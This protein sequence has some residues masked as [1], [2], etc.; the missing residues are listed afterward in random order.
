MMMNLKKTKKRITSIHLLDTPGSED[1][2][3]SQII[4]F[5]LHTIYNRPIQEKYPKDSRVAM[6]FSCTGK[7]RKFRSTK[8][9]PADKSSITMKIK[10]ANL[11]THCWK[12]CLNPNYDSMG[13][14]HCGW[15]IKDNFLV[16]VWYEGDNLPSD[17]EYEAHIDGISYDEE[18]PDD[19]DDMTDCF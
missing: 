7:N 16:P 13:P 12:Q 15:E 19:D 9:I 2:N 18:I 8:A 4:D 1:T 14:T 10:R 11:V 5:V 17:A 6:L 3:F